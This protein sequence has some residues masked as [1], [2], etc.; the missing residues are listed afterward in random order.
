MWW[1]WAIE[2][3]RMRSLQEL[4]NKRGSALLWGEWIPRH[5]PLNLTGHYSWKDSIRFSDGRLGTCWLEGLSQPPARGRHAWREAKSARGHHSS[6]SLLPSFT[7]LGDLP[8]APRMFNDPRNWM[9]VALPLGWGVTG[10]CMGSR[11]G[12]SHSYQEGECGWAVYMFRLQMHGAQFYRG[13]GNRLKPNN[14]M[15]ERHLSHLVTMQRICL[16]LNKID[17]CFKIRCEAITKQ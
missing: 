5:S 13:K 12:K 1:Q 7:G 10:A 8:L 16:I 3:D 14:F 2:K 6:T 15:L 9:N 4:Q 17:F 11:S